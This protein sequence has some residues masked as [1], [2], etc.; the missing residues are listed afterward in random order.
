MGEIMSKDIHFRIR[1]LSVTEVE[2]LRE[3]AHQVTGKKSIAGLAKKLLYEQGFL[4]GKSNSRLK[5]DNAE[6]SRFEIRLNTDDQR[7]LEE[8]AAQEGMTLNGYVA[9][10]LH[11]YVTKEPQLTTNEVQAIRE[12]NYQLY[13]IGN[14]LNQVAKALNMEEVSANSVKLAAI[15]SLQ[16]MMRQH[17]LTVHPLIEK[18]YNQL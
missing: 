3:K 17:M 16:A 13:K 1:G 7:V 18:N 15:E 11:G 10:L 9:M 12:S 2:L 8:L 5:N 14:N 4:M 6:Q